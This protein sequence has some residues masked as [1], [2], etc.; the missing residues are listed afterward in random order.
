MSTYQ[1]HSMSPVALLSRGMINVNTF[2]YQLQ[3]EAGLFKPLL[4]SK[5]KQA[6]HDRAM[7]MGL[8]DPHKA[9]YTR[10]FV[11]PSKK[12]RYRVDPL[13]HGHLSNVQYIRE[14]TLMEAAIKLQSLYRSHQDRK[15]AE[16]ATRYSGASLPLCLF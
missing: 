5:H 10:F 7:S 14:R 8:A 11:K 9:D 4:A 16:L 6:V 1:R 15:I 12:G 13:D 3:Y 2:T